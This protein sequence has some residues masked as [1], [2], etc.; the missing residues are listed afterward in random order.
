MNFSRFIGYL[1]P[2]SPSIVAIGQFAA[3]G[4]ALLSAPI[5][6]RAIGPEGRGETAAVLAVTYMWPLIAG[7]GLPLEVRR[8]AAE[9]GEAHVLRT[10]RLWMA[11]SFAPSLGVAAVLT[12]TLFDSFSTPERLAAALAISVTPFAISWMCDQSVLISRIQY[13]RVAIVQVLQ[14]LVYVTLISLGWLFGI[15]GVSYVLISN[16]FAVVVTCSVSALLVRVSLRG[17]RL[18]LGQTLRSSLPFAGNSVADATTNRLDQLLALPIMGGQAAG[19]YAVA[20]TAGALAM[21]LGHALAAS[22]FNAVARTPA[23]QRDSVIVVRTREAL[24]VSL[25]ASVMVIA[26]IPLGVPALFGSQF[27]TAVGPAIVCTVG[28]VAAIAGYVNTL[29]LAGAGKGRVLMGAQVLRLITAISLLIW[30]GSVIGALG[31]AIASATGTW[32][33]LLALASR[34]R[35]GLHI[36][37]IRPSDLVGAM[38]RLRS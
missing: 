14:P 11:F 3:S 28:G 12:F 6:A 24:A 8:V 30:L 25:V 29:S 16:A 27:E 21:P 17:P 33:L 23:T 18:P 31:A 5:V 9:S 36:F 13:G 32:V 10:A 34:T 22:A 19:L 15:I 1:N 20:A 38:R 37:A 2:S 4:L 7:L 26:I 35:G